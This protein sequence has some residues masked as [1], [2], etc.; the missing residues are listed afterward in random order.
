MQ[1]IE[2]LLQQAGHLVK[3]KPEEI[4]QRLEKLLADNKALSRQLAEVKTKAA[5]TIL[6]DADSDIQ[7]INDVKVVV[8]KV[9]VDNPAGLRDLADRF[10]DK[11]QSGVIVLASAVGNKVMLIARVTK[12]LTGQY[13]AGNIIKAV[14]AE[15]GGGGGGRPDMAQAGGSQPENMDRALETARKVI[16][17][18]N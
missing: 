5:A 10:A 13:H 4:S 8:K 16:E 14:A 2:R 18:S 1:E 11:L 15:V 9:T 6:D 7:V 12:D 3:A 17:R